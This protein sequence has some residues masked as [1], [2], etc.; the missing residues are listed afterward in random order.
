MGNLGEEVDIE[1]RRKIILLNSVCLIGFVILIP[2]GVLAFYE[3]DTYL[4][5]FDF[6]MAGLLMANVIL[7][8]KTGYYKLFIYSSVVLAMIFFMYLFIFGGIHN[9]AFVWYYT[10]P[11][12]SLFLLGLFH[13]SVLTFILFS[14]ALIFFM[15]NPHQPYFATYPLDLKL[16]F[17]P[18]FITVYIF[19]FTFEYLRDKTQKK[20]E[21]SLKNVEKEKLIAE[22]ANRAKSEFLANMSHELRTPLNHIIGFTELIIGK[23]FGELNPTQ[24]E[25]LK[26]VLSSSRLLLA[27]IN[28]ILDLSKIEAG[29]LELDLTR[30]KPRAL[31]ESSL[32]IVK[33]RCLKKGIQTFLNIEHLP[34][35]IV[36]DERKLKQILNNL[37][38]NAVKFTPKGGKIYLKADTIS[39]FQRLPDKIGDKHLGKVD[40]TQNFLRISVSDTGI[41][42]KPEDQ[43]RIFR[44]FEQVDSSMSRKYQGTGLGLSLTKRLVELHGGMIWVESA[45]EGKGS[46]FTFT[47]PLRGA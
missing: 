29:K 13:G 17:I 28:D 41:G 21:E 3:A 26:D 24:E 8:R 1:Y 23:N 39:E 4:G 10:F 11:L 19:A 22:R 30:V 36:V 7:L 32:I 12:F 25:Y 43:E 35:F 20:L 38:S 2:M 31:L 47:I 5:T 44:P 9:T 27:L 37:L 15:I 45:G 33:E 34:D 16:R 18:S 42:I 6:I 40:S 46:T 14:S